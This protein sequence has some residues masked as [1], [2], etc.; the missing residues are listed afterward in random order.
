M[1]PL[2]LLPL[3]AVASAIALSG[4]CTTRRC[5]PH[6]GEAVAKYHF[7][8]NSFQEALQPRAE[9]PEKV[10]MLVLSGGGSQGAWGAG[11]LRGWRENTANPRPK[12]FPVVTGVSTGALLATYAFL[13]EPADDDLLEQAYTTATTSDIYK[14]KFILFALF[15]DSIYNSKPLAG[16]VKK[17][18]TQGTV[19]RV[20]AGGQEGRRLYVGTVNHD[21]GSLVIWDLTAIAMD[22]N[23]PGRLDLYQKVVLA[24]ASIPI[25][26]QPVTIDGNL[27]ADGGARAQLFFEKGFSPAFQKMKDQKTLHPNLTLHIIVNGKLGL[28]SICVSDCLK[29]IALRT[30]DMLLDANEIGDLY[31]IEYVLK[32]NRYGHFALSWI[33]QAVQVT[34][35][36]V[37]DPKMMRDLYEASRTFGR[38]KA[39]WDDHIPDLDLSRH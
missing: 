9:T 39:K 16:R 13:G 26:V 38:T 23:N 37:F 14:K 5:D 29:E 7:E 24:S 34:T 33:P 10:D 21:S 25:L 35:S 22:T 11:V 1:N 4:C 28:D 31:H 12:K 27:Y 19:D 17:Y 32:L 36:D 3:A 8:T 20:A 2:N 6:A 18:I 30:L 15:S